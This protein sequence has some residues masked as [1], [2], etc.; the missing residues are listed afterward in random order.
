MLSDR[1]GTS[2]PPSSALPSPLPPPPG[3]PLL[4]M[5]VCIPLGFLLTDSEGDGHYGDD[6][7]CWL[8]YDTHFIW[9]FIAPVLVII[10]VR[11]NDVM[12]TVKLDTVVISLFFTDQCWFPCHGIGD[13]VP[14]S[15]QAHPPEYTAEG[16]ALDESLCVSSG[17]H[18][19]HL[20]DGGPGFH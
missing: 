17:C 13:H 11:W 3:V 15:T 20:G 1:N 14:P 4:Y 16:Q 7:A 2:P 8:R 10:L 6:K 12:I 9:A 5:V 18:G 19:D